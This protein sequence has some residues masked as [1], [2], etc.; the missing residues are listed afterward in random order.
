[1]RV[2]VVNAESPFE[3]SVDGRP[4]VTKLQSGEV[5]DYLVLSAGKHTISLIPTLKSVAATTYSLDVVRGRSM[6]LA[7]ASLRAGQ[8][9]T[10]FEDK[11]NTN[12]LKSLVT[13]YHLDGRAGAL[14]VLTADGNTKVFS[15]LAYG[16]SSSI[17][18]NP[19]SVELIA[20]KSGDEAARTVLSRTPLSMTQG[21]TFSVFLIPD[22]KGKLVARTI[23]NKTERYTGG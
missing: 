16:A 8:P 5:S 3:V 18:V 20:A 21:A 10:T 1:M 19:I 9:P 13:A 11:A 2:L 15:N 7:F 6:T 14:D 17:Q 12:K 23:Q 4:R 22:G